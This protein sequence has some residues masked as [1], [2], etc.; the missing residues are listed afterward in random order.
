[1]IR[2]S[3]LTVRFGDR[4]VIDDISLEIAAGEVVGIMGASGGGKTT[5]L[6]CMAGLLKPTEGTVEIMGVDINRCSERE[7]DDV[8]LKLGVLFQGAALFDYLNVFENVA[9]GVSRHGRLSKAELKQLVE[10]RLRR[11]G[12]QET[13]KLMPSEL[14]GGMKKRVGLARALATAPQILLY[15]EPTSGLDP[16][17]A[18]SIDSLILEL[19]RSSASASVVISHDLY[20]AARVCNRVAFIYEGKIIADASPKEFFETR[21][22]RIR[23]LIDK[24]EAKRIEAN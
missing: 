17:T 20:S 19:S 1:M 11:V 21:D 10:D 13:E 16:I 2:V 22:P 9:F 7:R 3:G 8:M 24:A 14:S 4:T 12:L 18:Y 6:R 15:D 23:E 5:L